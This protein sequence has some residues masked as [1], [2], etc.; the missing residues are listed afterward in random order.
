VVGD[1]PIYLLSASTTKNICKLVMCK[2]L[3]HNQHQLSL[4]NTL[5]VNLNGSRTGLDGL[6]F[7]FRVCLVRLEM[8]V[9]CLQFGLVWFPD[10]NSWVW[11]VMGLNS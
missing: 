1:L 8:A 5:Q 6:S 4:T 11:L 3:C 9:S 2:I 10:V 7:S